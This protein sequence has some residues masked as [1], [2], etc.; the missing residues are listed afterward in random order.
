ML[1]NSMRPA[2]N[3]KGWM[4]FTV[5][6][7]QVLHLGG[8]SQTT[9]T[10]YLSLGNATTLL[11]AGIPQ[12]SAKT[13]YIEAPESDTAGHAIKRAVVKVISAATP[14]TPVGRY[15]YDG[16]TPTATLGSQLDGAGDIVD[17]AGR[18]A[19]FNF[20]LYN[21]GGGNMVVEV[22]VEE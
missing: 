4:S 21:N 19:I 1:V 20:K 7:G 15:A 22:T 16:S 12:N 10:A 9:P 5:P 18:S 2:V 3:G 14:G 17:V 6:T 13:K 8:A 11:S